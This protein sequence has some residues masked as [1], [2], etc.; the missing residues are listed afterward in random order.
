MFDSDFLLILSLPSRGGHLMFVVRCCGLLFS[1][2]VIIIIHDTNLMLSPPPL[3]A[4]LQLNEIQE[5][6]ARSQN[7]EKKNLW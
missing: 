6:G 2:V 3:N 7:L 1:D 4:S 5:S